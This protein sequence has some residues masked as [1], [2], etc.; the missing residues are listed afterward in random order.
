MRIKTDHRITQRGDHKMVLAHFE[1]GHAYVVASRQSLY[2]K[3]TISTHHENCTA[4]HER[5][6]QALVDAAVA[7]GKK[8]PKPKRLPPRPADMT[9]DTRAEA[10]EAMFDVALGA[11]PADGYSTFVPYYDLGDDR[12]LHLRDVP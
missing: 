7:E 11:L 2:G 3:W 4:E 12:K 6:H 5:H 10:V 8:E 9:V 1:H